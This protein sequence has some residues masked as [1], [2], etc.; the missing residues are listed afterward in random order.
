MQ[1]LDQGLSVLIVLQV[2]FTVVVA[3]K[4]HHLRFFPKEGDM[5]GGD[6]NGNALPGT[7]IERD[8]THPFEYDFCE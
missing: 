7:L 3:S 8:V 5:R 2:K 4:R 6:R 1:S